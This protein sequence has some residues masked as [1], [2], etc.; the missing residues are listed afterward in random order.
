MMMFANSSPF[1]DYYDSSPDFFTAA[2]TRPRPRASPFSLVTHDLDVFDGGCY[3]SNCYGNRYRG[4]RRPAAVLRQQPRYVELDMMSPYVYAPSPYAEMSRAALIAQQR[5]REKA[6]AQARFEAQQRRQQQLAVARARAAA[7][8]EA[9][10]RAEVLEWQE[11]MKSLDHL[12]HY[13]MGGHDDEDD[14]AEQEEQENTASDYLQDASDLKAQQEQ[15]QDKREGEETLPHDETDH[16]TVYVST[17][18]P[19]HGWQRKQYKVVNQQLVEV[20]SEQDQEVSE[21]LTEAPV[22]APTEYKQLDDTHKEDDGNKEDVEKYEDENDEEDDEDDEDEDDRSNY[23]SG[24]SSQS[25]GASNHN[26]S[27]LVEVEDVDSDEDDEKEEF[28]MM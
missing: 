9:R 8:A 17:F 2:H 3:G 4:A 10:R 16:V 22:N 27:S 24:S 12:M 11:T 7:E 6:A 20:G 23:S 25:S 18:D 13:M 19:Q 28:V 21:K 5:Q 1:F 15:E 26:S 14:Q